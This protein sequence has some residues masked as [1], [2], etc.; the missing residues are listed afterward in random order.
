MWYYIPKVN[1]HQT[2]CARSLKN[3][4]NGGNAYEKMTAFVMALALVCTNVPANLHVQTGTETVYAAQET[5][6]NSEQDLIAMQNNPK[7][8]YYLA[9]DITIKGNLNLFPNYY[10]YD[11]KV[12]HEECFTGSLDGKGHTIKNYT[13]M[14]LFN[15]AK[16]QRL[17]TLL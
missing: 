12:Q 2:R 4:H 3:G 15:N 17:K 5:A 14:G 6:I 10:D 9:K 8:N 11:M 1:A 13:G 7:G 16:M